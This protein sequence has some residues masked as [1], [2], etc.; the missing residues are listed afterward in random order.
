M[1]V[2]K[3]APADIVPCLSGARVFDRGLVE[4]PATVEV[5]CDWAAICR[6]D[7]SPDGSHEVAAVACAHPRHGSAPAFA[8][9]LDKL[10]RF[11]P[12]ATACPTCGDGDGWLDPLAEEARQQLILGH[13][14]GVYRG[15]PIPRLQPEQDS[16]EGTEGAEHEG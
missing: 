16:N 4:A 10:A 11:M 14:L 3:I 12:P 7:L 1:R 13:A 5:R 2:I 8:E 9:V 6:V 15:I